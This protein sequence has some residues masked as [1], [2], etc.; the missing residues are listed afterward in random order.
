[1]KQTLSIHILLMFS[2]GHKMYKGKAVAHKLCE[3]CGIED[4]A[5]KASKDS[6]SVDL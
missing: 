4:F 2:M 6:S 3:L 5:D 1:M